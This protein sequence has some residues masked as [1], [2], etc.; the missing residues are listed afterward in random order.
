M[1]KI[2]DM[3]ML[4]HNG[5][6]SLT[7]R[8]LRRCKES[9]EEFVAPQ[10]SFAYVPKV[11]ATQYH[12]INYLQPYRINSFAALSKC[13]NL[14][15]LDLSSIAY[16]LDLDS[17]MNSIKRLD[18]LDCL[19]YPRSC[20]LN[21][22]RKLK[23][24]ASWPMNLRELHI[25]GNLGE[26][27]LEFISN[28][29][30]SLTHLSIG[31][32]PRLIILSVHSLLQKLGPQLKT[33][34]IKH[35]RI[36]SGAYSLGEV[37]PYLPVLRRLSIPGEHIIPGFFN[38]ASELKSKG[39]F[40]LVELEISCSTGIP[41]CD[42]EMVINGSDIWNDVWNAVEDGGFGRLRTLKVHRSLELVLNQKARYDLKALND[43]LQ[44]LAEEDAEALCSHETI[45]AGV[46][47]IGQ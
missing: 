24:L 36:I 38:C 6:K 17:F 13:T 35:S 46:W 42:A 26:D 23:H 40:S 32:C 33:L 4:V 22:N 9:L 39:L 29:P 19:Y 18:K 10:V 28:F 34:E 47:I 30:P 1:V 20:T 45:N 44:A 14:R 37:L 2:L 21:N 3:S 5:S 25:P 43:L 16:T 31:Y 11:E 8:I 41:Y 15:R 7:A 12:H 27:S